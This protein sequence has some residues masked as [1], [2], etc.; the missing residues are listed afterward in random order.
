VFAF[1]DHSGRL[2]G[3]TGVGNRIVKLARP[4][5]V[6]ISMK[7]LRRGFGCYHAARQPAQILQK[8]MRHA[9]IAT[10]MAFCANVDAAVEAA[11]LKG[12]ECS[13]LRNSG[14]KADAEEAEEIG[15]T[16]ELS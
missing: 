13:V 12:R 16:S 3:P 5:G 6:K 1:R 10:T 9:N 7:K 2:I 4:A 14:A 11:V 15:T 8:L